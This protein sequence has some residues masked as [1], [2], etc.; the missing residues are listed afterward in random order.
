MIGDKSVVY[1]DVVN[2]IVYTTLKFLV[3]FSKPEY[4]KISALKVQLLSVD[5]VIFATL[6]EHTF[7]TNGTWEPVYI[8]LPPGYY[9]VGFEGTVGLLE[10]SVIIAIKD[11]VVEGLCA[12]E[13][14]FTTSPGK[15]YM[16]IENVIIL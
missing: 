6:Y 14:N 4:D 16:Q 8:C 5:D 7:N 13:T 1:S 15:W 9:H 3:Y 11:F 10:E 2:V 12:D